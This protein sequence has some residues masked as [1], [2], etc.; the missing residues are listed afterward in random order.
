MEKAARDRRSGSAE[1]TG[2]FSGQRTD[3]RQ[4][5][6]ERLPIDTIW[7]AFNRMGEEVVFLVADIQVLYPA[8][9]LGRS[10]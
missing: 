10:L 1:D 8:Y 9:T 3:R 6:R 5:I 2:K 4:M 7:S